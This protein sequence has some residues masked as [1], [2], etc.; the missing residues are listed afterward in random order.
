[1][2]VFRIIANFAAMNRPIKLVYVAPSLY[3]AGGVERVLTLKANYFADCFGYDVTVVTTDGA[4]RQPAFAL[5]KNVKVE[6]LDINF[7]ELWNRPFIQKAW[8][9]LKKQRAFRRRLGAFLCEKHPDITISLLRR[10]INFINS[11][12]DG[13][14]KIGE[15]HINRANY[16]TV[17]GGFPAKLFQRYW[18]SRLVSHL[19]RLKKLV[20]LT[21]ADRLS[22]PELDNVMTIPN[23]QSFSP[24]RQSSLESRRVIAVCR[25]SQEKGIDL[26]LRAWKIVSAE[27]DGWELHVYGDGNREPYQML[28]GQLGISP[29]ALVLHSRTDDVESEL[30]NSSIAVC[31]SRFEGFGIA[32][33]EAMSCGVPVVSFDCPWGPASMIN[34]HVDGVLVPNGDVEM[35]ANGISTLIGNEPLRH[36]L[37]RQAKERASDFSIDSIAARW[38]RLFLDICGEK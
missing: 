15:M 35:L 29:S 16:R 6:C 17:D 12:G 37:G 7:D 32:I 36:Q 27:N 23:P 5:S 2:V 20:V 13:S 18:A 24:S 4:H 19:S 1:M 21:D 9:Y 34:D 28:A 38:Q 3:I 14:F 11:I 26:L 22:W 30:C 10:E 8:L 25:Y 33:L 31:S